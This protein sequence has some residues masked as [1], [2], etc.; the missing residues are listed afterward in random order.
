MNKDFGVKRRIDKD[1][2][3]LIKRIQRA[4][5]KNGTGDLRKRNTF[6]SRRITLAITRHKAFQDF[7]VPDIIKADLK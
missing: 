5:I 4:K 7:V 1:F 6:S 3:E 2:D